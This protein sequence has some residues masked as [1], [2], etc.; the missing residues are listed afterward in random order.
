MLS[1]ES[2]ATP[3]VKKYI[4]KQEIVKKSSLTVYDVKDGFINRIP[5]YKSTIDNAG[6]YLELYEIEVKEVTVTLDLET[7]YTLGL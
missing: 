2:Q 6:K 7:S 3:F 4:T 5:D 1:A